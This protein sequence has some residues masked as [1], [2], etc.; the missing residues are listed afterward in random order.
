MKLAI[1]IHKNQHDKLYQSIKYSQQL[2]ITLKDSE[3]VKS[4]VYLQNLI[5]S[6]LAIVNNCLVF[7]ICIHRE[8]IAL[9]A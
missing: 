1:V 4:P 9:L 3:I 2:F 5:F 7:G 8:Y 6:I